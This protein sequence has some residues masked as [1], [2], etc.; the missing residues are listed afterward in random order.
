MH[1]I[2]QWR[3][4]IKKFDGYFFVFKTY[5]HLLAIGCAAQIVEKAFYLTDKVS[6]FESVNLVLIVQ[7]KP[8]TKK[9]LR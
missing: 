5:F 9:T 6:D 7:F 8:K 3:K 1:N 2:N 4:F